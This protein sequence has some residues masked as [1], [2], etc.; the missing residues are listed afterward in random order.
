MCISYIYIYIFLYSFNRFHISF[1]F[2]LN[3]RQPITFFAFINH[4]RQSKLAKERVVYIFRPDN[5]FYSLFAESIL[6]VFNIN[7]RCFY[8]NTMQNFSF[9]FLIYSFCE[10]F[11]ILSLVCQQLYRSTVFISQSAIHE[12]STSETIR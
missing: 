7:T 10:T 12:S 8:Q 6:Y 2:L 11:V 9:F 3:L 1:T 4:F 5:I